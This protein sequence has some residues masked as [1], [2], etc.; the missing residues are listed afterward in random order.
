MGS[1]MVVEFAPRTRTFRTGEPRR[2]ANTGEC[3]GYGRAVRQVGCQRNQPA[4][5]SRLESWLPGMDSNHNNAN[6]NGFCKL[7]RVRS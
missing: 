1:T 6:L 3:L 2:N 4:E 7:Q 5:S